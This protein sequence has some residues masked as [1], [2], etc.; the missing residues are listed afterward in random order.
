MN[1]LPLIIT[2]G[3]PSGI[4][5]EIAI[6]A[7]KEIKNKIP[8]LLMGDE[9]L[10]KKIA[11]QNDVDL[12]EVNKPEEIKSFKNKLCFLKLNYVVKPYPGTPNTKNSKI[13][14]KNIIDSVRLVLNG[15]CSAIVTSPIDKGILKEGTSFNF[16]GHTELLGDLCQTQSPPIMMMMSKKLKIV[17]ITTHIPIKEV[18]EMLS[19]DYIVEFI[20]KLESE[21]KIKFK[22]FSPKIILTGL[23]PHAG[24][25]GKIGNEEQLKILPA[26]QKLKKLGINIFGPISSDTA[27]LKKNLE[28]YDVFVCMYHDQALIPIKLLDFFGSI[29]ITLGLPIIRTS[30]DHG[31]A[32][33]IAG[34]NISDPTSMILAIEKAY[35]IYKNLS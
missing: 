28:N 23:N 18:S 19:I 6:K 13:V 16:P 22:I 35:S 26:I 20:K 11:Y 34:Q 25:N 27:F 14:L 21:V 32:Y 7:Y 4:G 2:C 31:T 5:P 17:P 12:K 29:N 15:K 8:L 10:L 9:N 3:E 1:N 30:P 33:D 24:E